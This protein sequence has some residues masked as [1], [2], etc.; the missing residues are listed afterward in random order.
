MALYHFHKSMLTDGI[1]RIGIRNLHRGRGVLNSCLK[2]L[3]CAE[4]STNL[5]RVGSGHYL[6][7]GLGMGF[8]LGESGYDTNCVECLLHRGGNKA[9]AASQPPEGIK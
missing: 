1:L 2:L 4:S 5:G 3:G 7:L 8:R 9:C 6:L